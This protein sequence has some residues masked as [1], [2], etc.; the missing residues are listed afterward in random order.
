MKLVSLQENDFNVEKAVEKVKNKTDKIGG[1]VS[2]LG[3]VRSVSKGEKVEKLDYKAYSDMA[4]EEMQRIREEALEEEGVHEVL[5][6]HRVGEL[7]LGENTILI[8]VGS[9]HR[10]EAFKTG[11]W[12]ID[13]V[14][15][16][17]PVWKKE[18]TEDDEH[19]IE[20]NMFKR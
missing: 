13:V 12:V 10:E 2:F 7:N 3:S 1:I 6:H 4:V 15:E 19:W 18:F 9:E 11:K 16:R 5:I 17:V 20:D 8:V 14:K